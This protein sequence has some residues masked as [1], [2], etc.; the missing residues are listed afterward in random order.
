[1]RD[2]E[3]GDHGRA[4]IGDQPADACLVAVGNRLV[5]VTFAGTRQAQDVLVGFF[6]NDVDNIVSGDDPD[7]PSV[8]IDDSGGNQRVFLEPQ[9]DLFLV[10]VDGDQCLLMRH[11][12]ADRNAALA[13]HDPAQFAGA[14]R[15]MLRV[16]DEDFPEFGG[17]ILMVAQIVDELAD[18]HMLGHRDQFALH[19]ASG[20]FFGVGQRVFDDGAVFGVQFGQ[21]GLLVLDLHVLDDRDGVIGVEL[22]GQ[23]GDLRWLQRVDNV[24]AD[25]VV[26]LGEHLGAHQIAHRNGK[27]PAAFGRCLLQKVGDIRLVQGFDQPLHFF[28]ITRFDGVEDAVHKVAGQDI[29]FIQCFH[30]FV[31]AEFGIGWFAGHVRPPLGLLDGNWPPP[32]R[33]S[34]KCNVFGLAT[35]IASPRAPTISS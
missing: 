17:Q 4:Q 18:R 28:A 22:S 32:K 31:V 27:R 33:P 5:N 26:D 30:D 15:L 10:H 8:A 14:H 25:I 20:G 3:A 1:M 29:V 13:A 11:D 19:D 16:D 12:F 34:S 9:R 35:A 23:I 2:D 21:N 7:E 6:L 24:F